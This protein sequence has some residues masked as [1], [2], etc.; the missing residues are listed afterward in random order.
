MLISKTGELADVEY[1]TTL[2]ENTSNMPEGL[3]T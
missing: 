1:T 3:D 2:G